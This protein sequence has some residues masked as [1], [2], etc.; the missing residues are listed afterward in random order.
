MNPA[1]PLNTV[2]RRESD[3]RS[4][5]VV[6]AGHRLFD[7]LS[8]AAVADVGAVIAAEGGIDP[9]AIAS[10]FPRL[11][12]ACLED[13]DQ[14][15]EQWTS[16]HLDRVIETLV[17][18][19]PA[20]PAARA[21]CRY[22][23]CPA[24]DRLRDRSLSISAALRR[25]L[26]DKRCAKRIFARV[27]MPTI[28]GIAMPVDPGS[29]AVARD[30]LGYPYVARAPFASSG[31]G[32]FLVR[33]DADAELVLGVPRAD[34][35]WLFEEYVTGYSLNTTGCVG[36]EHT[37]V[38]APSVQIPGEPE[39]SDLPFGFCGNDYP[40]AGA[41]ARSRAGGGQLADPDPWRPPADVGL[42]RR[43]RRAISSS[44]VVDGS[45]PARSIHAF[46]TRPPLLNFGLAGTP[47]STPA[48]AR[49]AT[50]PARSAS[51]AGPVKGPR[52]SQIIVH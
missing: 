42:S 49:L 47:G 5:G 44:T 48:A 35:P 45:F 50:S 28:E 23:G 21:C 32:T 39:C 36:V 51:S 34:G 25:Q 17:R 11:R 6:F 15:R 29:L 41:L 27:G 46:R 26:D 37:A 9:D 40:T 20:A 38:Y 12:T 1:N 43:V 8:V 24:A 33:S 31:L 4:P 19:G 3:S 14:L 7:G 52:L 13:L 22:A 30:R 10:R 2:G 18:G 16:A